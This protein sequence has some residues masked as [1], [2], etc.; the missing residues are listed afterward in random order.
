[1]PPL[2]CFRTFLPATGDG[3][4]IVP[5]AITERLCMGADGQLEPLTIGST[6]PV[7][8]TV[9]HAGIVKV[10]RYVFNIA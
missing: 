4:R 7:A 8:V 1:M 9:T 2:S 3:E 10:K 6:R 5:T